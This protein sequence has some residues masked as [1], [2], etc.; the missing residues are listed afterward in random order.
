MNA[1]ATDRRHAAILGTRVDA[2]GWDAALDTV[3]AWARGRESRYVC[4]ANVHVVVEA[5]RDDAF[6]ALLNDADLV[7]PDGMPLAWLLRRRGF[8]GQPR[9]SGPDFMWRFCARAA[10]DGLRVYLCGGRSLSLQRLAARL[11]REFPGLTVAGAEELPFRAA[12]AAECAETAARIDASGA[13]AVFVGLGCPKQE[14]W[15]AA[16]RGRVHAVMFGVGAALDFHAG[17]AARAPRWMQRH[18]LEWLHRLLSNP[19][20]LARR[21]LV[22]NSL[23]VLYLARQFLRRPFSNGRDPV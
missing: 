5:A 21:Y 1:S 18:G 13:H 17:T 23:F 12:T 2:L 6:R 4:H 10:R 11:A 16:Q 8:A 22:T 15:M 14:R 7:T 3:L 9:L 20:R 19:R